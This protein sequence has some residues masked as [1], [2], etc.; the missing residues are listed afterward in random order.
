MSGWVP[1]RTTLS[2]FDLGS[3][4]SKLRGWDGPRVEG[5]HSEARFPSSTVGRCRHCVVSVNRDNPVPHL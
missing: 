5:I 2:K 3:V 4:T 1:Q